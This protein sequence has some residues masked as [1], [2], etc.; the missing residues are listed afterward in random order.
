L[1]KVNEIFYSIQGESSFSGIP[2]VF[3][4]L[5]GCNL[6]CT[7][8]DTKY[9]YEE[10]REISVEQILKEVKKYKCPY[11]E[12][13]GGEPLIQ[14]ETPSLV[15]FLVNKGFSVL[16]ETN[17]TKDISVISNKATIIMDIKCPSS[18]ESNKID[19]ENLKRLESKDEV[20]F[21]IAGKSDY[22]WAKNVITD[23]KLKD[24]VKMLMSPVKERISAASLANW[25][26]EDNLNV[27]L[28]LQLHK[29]LWP[30]VKRGK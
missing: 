1:L 30:D 17:G 16:L 5:T 20:K 26:L 4:R 14:N 29:I 2:F 9:A 21:V 6:R 25:I 22:N 24:K 18:G 23:K 8:C 15:D 12:I 28:Q 10:G 3:V 7:Y 13:T 11:V 19:W 27:R